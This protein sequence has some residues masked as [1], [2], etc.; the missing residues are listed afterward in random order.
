MT[1]QRT[2]GILIFDGV[3]VLDFT[4][5]FEVFS[6]AG[7]VAG[8]PDGALAFTVVTIAEERKTILATGGLRVE[9]EAT[10]DAH[11]DIDVLVVPGGVGT[12]ILHDHAPVI[13]WIR[14]QSARVSLTTSVCTGAFLLGSAGL[15]EGRAATTHWASIHRMRDVFPNV[16]VREEMRFVEDGAIVTAAGISAGI[17]MSLAIVSRLL[18][19]DV[20]RKTA[21]HMEYDW[22]S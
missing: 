19:D 17:D 2:V 11:P 21:R 6:V 13:D 5:P 15:L 18:G 8:D 9:P 10:I 20:A 3:E 12:R 16:E 4:G 1:E 7:Q 22:R 14:A